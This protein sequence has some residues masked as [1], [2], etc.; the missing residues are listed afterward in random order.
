[1][2]NKILYVYDVEKKFGSGT[3]KIKKNTTFV[4]FVSE[5]QFAL[6]FLPVTAMVGIKNIMTFPMLYLNSMILLNVVY[7]LG[8]KVAAICIS[9]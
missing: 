2:L 9:L 8:F 4:L 3:S 7:I 5:E 6:P 1:M